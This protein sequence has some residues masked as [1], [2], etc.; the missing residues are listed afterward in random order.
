M[1]VKEFKSL[2]RGEKLIDCLP[3]KHKRFD[4]VRIYIYIVL[5]YIVYYIYNIPHRHTALA[6]YKFLNSALAGS[7]CSTPRPGR[8]SPGKDATPILQD[9]RWA[10]SAGLN[11][12]EFKNMSGSYR[13]STPGQDSPYHVTIRTGLSGSLPNHRPLYHSTQLLSC[14]LHCIFHAAWGTAEMISLLFALQSGNLER[15]KFETY[16]QPLSRT[17]FQLLLYY[18]ISVCVEFH[19]WQSLSFCFN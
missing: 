11:G 2:S 5:I 15:V 17:N 6:V 8:F 18:Y 4:V 19:T 7:D 10:P 1:N 3:W 14:V 9:V 16:L 12:L 13:H